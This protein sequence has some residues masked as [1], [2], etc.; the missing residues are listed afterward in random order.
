MKLRL[1]KFEDI[2]TKSK[3]FREVFAMTDLNH[4][5][6]VRYSTCWV[7]L[8]RKERSEMSMTKQETISE[9]PAEVSKLS[10]FESESSHLEASKSID[11]CCIKTS[12]VGFEWDLGG[13]ESP[14]EKLSEKSLPDNK[15]ALKHHI[16]DPSVLTGS[17]PKVPFLPLTVFKSFR[18]LL[19]VI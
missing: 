5:N 2:Q 16:R 18:I 9:L 11:D 17:L 8:E 10:E 12:S 3:V 13:D 15:V 1:A 19:K 4:P 7:E 14:T 6:I